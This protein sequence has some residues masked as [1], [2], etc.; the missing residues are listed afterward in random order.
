M[1][2][3]RGNIAFATINLPRLAMEAKGNIDAF[4]AGLNRMLGVAEEGL[5][6]RWN[7]V[8]KLRVKD[9]PFVMGEGIYMGSENLGP[10]DVIEPALKN[11]TLT[12]GFIGLAQALKTLTGSH[13]GESDESQSLGLA[14]VQHMRNVTNALSDKHDLNFSLMATP[15]EGLSD[16]FTKIDK[17]KYGVV[18]SVTDREHYTN[19]FHVPVEFEVSVADKVKIEAPYHAMCNAGHISYIEMSGPP[20]RNVEGLYSIL[21]YMQK[22]DMGY[23]GFNFPIDFCNQCGF[24]GVIPDEGCSGC[25]STDIRRTRRVTGY[26]SVG[27]RI[28]PG[29]DDEIKHRTTHAGKEVTLHNT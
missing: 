19:S 18:P 1:A 16:R 12:V 11:G 9:I 22:Q 6:H 2:D 17:R 4:Y 15:A 7:T 8:K 21:V 23:V 28:G 10:D 3:G 27:E 5:M 24:L 13:H 14:I 20:L 29:K 26:F 25:G